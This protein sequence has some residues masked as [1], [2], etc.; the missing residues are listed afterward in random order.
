MLDKEHRNK[1]QNSTSMVEMEEFVNVVRMDG[2][3][4]PPKGSL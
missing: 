3:Q 1:E 2:T 4:S